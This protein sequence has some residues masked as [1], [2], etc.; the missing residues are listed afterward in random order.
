M[1]LTLPTTMRG[2]AKVVPGKGVQIHYL[3]Y[4][5]DAFRN[6]EVDAKMSRC[7]TIPSTPEPTMPSLTAN[8]PSVIPNTTRCF[9]AVPKKKSCWQVKNY[10][11]RASAILSN[12]P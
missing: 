4:W 8:G 10:A 12:S 2:T 9:T 3:F 6:P 11:E 7:A 1:I 5:S